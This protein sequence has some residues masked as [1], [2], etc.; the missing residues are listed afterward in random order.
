VAQA[1]VGR[2]LRVGAVQYRPIP[3]D[4][5][6]NLAALE[7]L[8][9]RAAGR[10]ASLVVLPELCTTGLVLGE[11]AC[12]ARWAEPLGGTS[13]ARLGRVARAAGVHLAAGLPTR[14]P[15]GAL[16]NTQVLLGP[17]GELLGH[18]HKNHLYGPD[19]SWAQPGR[20]YRAVPTALGVIGLCVCFDVNFPGAWEA[21]R[22][23]GAE[24]VA[25]STA[26]VDDAPPW[27][28]WL[29]PV[30]RYRVALV[31]GNTWGQEGGIRFSGGSGVVHPGGG[32]L[33]ATGREG[34]DVAVADLLLH[35]PA[36]HVHR[37]IPGRVPGAPER[38][39]VP[40]PPIRRSR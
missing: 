37:Q 13:T 38:S 19:F 16:H 14:S 15:E 6:R 11:P 36:D 1:G 34:D 25:F 17:R 39:P 10:G 8:V 35:A 33:A 4:P 29:A 9:L 22:A 32:L 7:A 5:G 27:P 21:L 26:W 40:Q 31:A 18:Y 24:V 12:A 2:I 30:G 23:A 28:H 20:G 3:R